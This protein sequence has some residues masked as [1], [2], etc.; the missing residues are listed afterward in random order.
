MLRNKLRYLLLLAAIA[1]LSVLYNTYYMGIIFLTVL[2]MPFMMF[3]LL[4]YMYGKIKA[5]LVSVAH[6]VNKGEAMP[7]SVQLNNPTIFPISNLKIYLTYKNSY[8]SKKYTKEFLVS[9]DARSKSSVICN[10]YSDY[11]GNMEISLKAIRVY[12]YLKLFSLKRKLKII[13]L[14]TF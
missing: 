5:E 1:F 3:G 8:S 14:Y 13:I 10:L 4:S 12:D 6:I 2:V 9:A 7:I 11:A